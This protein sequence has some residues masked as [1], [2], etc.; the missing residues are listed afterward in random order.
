MGHGE[1]PE[2]DM[3]ERQACEARRAV[4]TKAELG[5]SRV[6]DFYS[7]KGGMSSILV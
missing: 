3:K 6:W 7:R 4:E 5:Q 1:E 2:L